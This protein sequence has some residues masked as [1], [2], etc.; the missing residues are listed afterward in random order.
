[1][2]ELKLILLITL[3]GGCTPS[4]PLMEIHQRVAKEVE[5]LIDSGYL[6]TEYV[7]VYELSSND[8]SCIYSISISDAPGS[9]CAEYPSRV[10]KYKDK[11]LCFIEL[12]EPEMTSEQL[13]KDGIVRDSTL[14]MMNQVR[15]QRDNM[16][17]LGISKY[18]ERK[19]LF[20]DT[21]DVYVDVEY[22]ELWPYFSGE[23]PQGK[24]VVMTMIEHDVVVADTS[25]LEPYDYYVE[26]PDRDS[27]KYYANYLQGSIY[28][29]NLTDAVMTLSSNPDTL[30][31]IGVVNGK[32]TLKLL[33]DEELPLQIEPHDANWLHYKSEPTATF[34][35]KLPDKPFWTS[36][37]K[38]L[39]DSTYCFLYINGK[40][41][42]FRLL[43]ND[44][45]LHS[46]YMDE[47]AS[48][49]YIFYN[50]G[51]YNKRKR[52]SNFFGHN[53]VILP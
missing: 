47:K 11:Y 42:N 51:V 24:G 9:S 26:A 7:E 34:F 17:L 45:R 31:T 48:N 5:L 38:L 39:S 37:H 10:I 43:Y 49:R 4:T 21:A 22:P 19:V 1:M 46:Y 16:W 36:L 14:S 29:Y 23:N 6:F 41:S 15:H 30:K 27:V 33:L 53:Y 8:S 2:K 44:M 25:I 20:K 3:L 18:N 50:E 35:K 40:P 52:E 28:V 32:D 13:I 12:D